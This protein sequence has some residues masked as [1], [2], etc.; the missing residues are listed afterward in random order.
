MWQR[1]FTRPSSTWRL[2]PFVIP[3][4]LSTGGLSRAQAASVLGVDASLTDPSLLKKAFIQRAKAVHPDVS[5][6]PVEES[7]VEFRQA[8]QAFDT[9]MQ[10]EPAKPP[11]RG[12]V[13]STVKWEATWAHE[14]SRAG[15]EWT[16][17][18]CRPNAGALERALADAEVAPHLT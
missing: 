4:A 10:T 16:H 1:L 17:A 12:G 9:L 13:K 7:K 11:A 6:K 18:W 14:P 15:P 3:R 5:H 8:L 2:T